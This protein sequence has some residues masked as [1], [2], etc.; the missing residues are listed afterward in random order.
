[1]RE[2]WLSPKL[3]NMEQSM[4]LIG[5]NFR[6]FCDGLMADLCAKLSVSREE[7]TRASLYI[8]QGTS[9]VLCGRYSPDPVLR[10][11]GRPSYPDDQGCI[12]SGWR[13]SWHFENDMGVSDEQYR[14]KSMERYNIDTETLKTIP[15]KSLF[16]AVKRIDD[17]RECVGL[18]VV[19]ST[20]QDRFDEGTIK[21]DLEKFEDDFSRIIGAFK[22]YAPSPSTAAAEGY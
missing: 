9:F 4:A 15:M 8:H 7:V 5:A 17:G 14:T 16:F 2:W 12:A 10:Q 21:A 18:V 11:P 22:D 19:E 1:M 3:A 6:T 20:R 13:N